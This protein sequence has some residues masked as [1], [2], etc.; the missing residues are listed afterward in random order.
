MAP[1][2]AFLDHRT[3]RTTT[4][5]TPAHPEL[6][7]LEPGDILCDRH[8]YDWYVVTDIDNSGVGLR[9]NETEYMLPHSL[10]CSIYGR[11]LFHAEQTA[12][13]DVP[14]WCKTT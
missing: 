4:A 13:L 8:R 3:E 5:T 2:Q 6:S 1:E 12:N 11:R 14:D 7:T 9:D 10:F